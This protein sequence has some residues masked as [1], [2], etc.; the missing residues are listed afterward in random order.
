MLIE[1]GLAHD[2]SGKVKVEF[3]P[4]GVRAS[5]RAPLEQDESP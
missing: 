2:M 4:G 3:L 5:V 1:R